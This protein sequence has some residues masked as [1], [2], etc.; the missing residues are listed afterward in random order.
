MRIFHS[1]S[2]GMCY[3]A[4]SQRRSNSNGDFRRVSC[5]NLA[6]QHFTNHFNLRKWLDRDWILT[7]ELHLRQFPH[8]RVWASLMEPTSKVFDQDLRIDP[9]LNP[10]HARAMGRKTGMFV[11]QSLSSGGSTV[12]RARRSIRLSGL[13]LRSPDLPAFL[14]P[15]LVLG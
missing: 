8:D 11:G 10:L 9:V 15:L 7:L 13:C 5:T 14:G 2:V 6:C 3:M 1:L 4:I 12:P